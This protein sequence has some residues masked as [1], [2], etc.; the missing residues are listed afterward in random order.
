M[1]ENL[2]IWAWVTLLI[3]GVLA[4]TYFATENV[5][6]DEE[7]AHDAPIE[8]LLPTGIDEIAAVEIIV[9]DRAHRFER[10]GD[11]AWYKHDHTHKAGSSKEAHRHEI[12]VDAASRIAKTFT[13]FSRT[14]VERT[15]AKLPLENNVYGTAV[16]EM[17]VVIF[18]IAEVQPILSLHIGHITPDGFARYVVVVQRNA[19]VTIP[20]YQVAQ[21]RDLVASFNGRQ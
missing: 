13:T 6:D 21:L 17:A 10:H 8:F 5:D 16:P 15:I 12:A 19:V 7:S 11:G 2:K 4:S 18:S 1:G 3:V 14:R 20:E 9:E